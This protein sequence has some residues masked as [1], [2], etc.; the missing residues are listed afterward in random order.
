LNKTLSQNQ[1]IFIKGD[2]KQ[3]QVAVNTI[4]FIEA[5][6]NYCKVVLEDETIITLQKISEFEKLLSSNFIRV[7]KSFLIA[8]KKIKTIE[9]YTI[10]IEQHKI[11]IGQTY[12]SIVKN[13]F[14]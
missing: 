2:K 7:H 1:R 8:K 11:P 6:G 3:H 13:L 9:S 12:R 4:L 14:S 10:Y 5:Y